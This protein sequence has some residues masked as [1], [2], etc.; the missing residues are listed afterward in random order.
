MVEGVA[1]HGG[2]SGRGAN[3]VQ[4]GGSRDATSPARMGNT[5]KRRMVRTQQPSVRGCLALPAARVEHPASHACEGGIATRVHIQ[6]SGCPCVVEHAPDGIERALSGCHARTRRTSRRSLC[7][8]GYR[9]GGV[10]FEPAKPIVWFETPRATWMLCRIHTL[11]HWVLCHGRQLRSEAGPFLLAARKSANIVAPVL[12]LVEELNLR[13]AP[14]SRFSYGRL[15]GMWKCRMNTVETDR[16]RA[17]LR[18]Q[19]ASVS[20]SE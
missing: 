3:K 16:V 2:H 6:A 5:L 7:P 14:N 13:W 20:A 12:V 15:R 1:S 18:S 19:K 8:A 11:F 17:K 10:P 4:G 9:W